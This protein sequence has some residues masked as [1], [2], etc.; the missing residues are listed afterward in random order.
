MS[1]AWP[2]CTVP[3]CAEPAEGAVE[4]LYADPVRRALCARHMRGIRERL[5]V[6]LHEPALAPPPPVAV[7]PGQVEAFSE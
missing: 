6:L 3:R 5:A 2:S 4:L 7:V 1:H